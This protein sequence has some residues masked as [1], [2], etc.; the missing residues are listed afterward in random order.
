M[1]R[2]VSGAAAVGVVVDAGPMLATFLVDGLLCDG[3]HAGAKWAAGWAWLPPIKAL[4][5]SPTMAVG[6]CAEGQKACAAYSG[7]VARGFVYERALMNS[8]LV[9]S[10]RALLGW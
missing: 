4:E 9:A 5:G 7:S 10:S 1:A 2:V 8:E 3:G 6:A